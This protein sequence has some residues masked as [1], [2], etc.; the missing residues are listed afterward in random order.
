MCF[1]TFCFEYIIFHNMLLIL[2]PHIN[3]II[4][5]HRVSITCLGYIFPLIVHLVQTRF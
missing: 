2:W 4:V 1:Y 5:G 3:F